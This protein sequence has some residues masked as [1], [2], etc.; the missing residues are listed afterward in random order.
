MPFV[1]LLTCPSMFPYN[2]SGSTIFAKFFVKRAVPLL[3]KCNLL[4]FREELFTLLLSIKR[5]PFPLHRFSSFL[6]SSLISSS[7]S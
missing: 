7:T 1:R 2:Q 6:L 4:L 5:I 3:L